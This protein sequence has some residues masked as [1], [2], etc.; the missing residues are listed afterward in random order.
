MPF[1]FPL[2]QRTVHNCVL[3]K[4]LQG[5][6]QASNPKSVD[7]NLDGFEARLVAIAGTLRLRQRNSEDELKNVFHVLEHGSMFGSGEGLLVL[8][9]LR[10]AIGRDDGAPRRRAIRTVEDIPGVS[11]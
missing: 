9:L 1:G 11:S 2:V 6:S 4:L 7:F 8:L 10:V 3:T 5:V